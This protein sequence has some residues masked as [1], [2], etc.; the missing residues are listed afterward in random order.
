[1]GGGFQKT[2]TQHVEIELD[3]QVDICGMV[4]DAF[5]HADESMALEERTIEIV[6]EEFMVVNGLPREVAEGYNNGEGEVGTKI[7]REYELLGDAVLEDGVE[8][9][10]FDP[11]ALEE[12]K[13]LYTSTKCTELAATIVLMNLCIVHGVNNKFVDELFTLL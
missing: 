5:Q 10:I 6:E 13:P 1:L 11:V 12:A 8:D 9:N 4:E 2:T 3:A 7:E